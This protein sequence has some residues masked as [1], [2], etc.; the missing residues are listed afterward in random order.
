M[1]IISGLA[2]GVDEL[3]HTIAVDNGCPTIAVTGS[4][5]A[6]DYLYPRGNL[7]LAEKIIKTGGLLVSEFSPFTPGQPANFPRRNRLISGL[8]R[9]V[10]VAEAS[11][12]SGALITAGCAAEQNRE[13]L[14]LPQNLNS[15]T[16]AGVNR[17]L[18]SGAK[19]IAS[20]DDILEALDIFTGGPS[21]AT[22]LTIDL[23][24]LS[25]EEKTLY[26]L[27]SASPCHVDKIMEN[28][29]LDASIVGAFLIQL[30]IK[31]IIKNIGGQNYVKL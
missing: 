27:L 6:W 3:A 11:A 26:Q 5:L 7:K 31:G 1:T 23:N 24:S 21:S 17:L 18:S 22:G 2:Y 10:M 14:A 25:P 19:L 29:T 4:G 20:A 15:P 16:A 13:V 12:K 30:E 8:A 28:S 9:A